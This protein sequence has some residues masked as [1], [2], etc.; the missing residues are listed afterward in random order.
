[1][2]RRRDAEGKIEDGQTR[3]NWRAEPAREGGGAGGRA[4]HDRRAVD[5]AGSSDLPRDPG[6]TVPRERGGGATR[7]VPGVG[8]GLKRTQIWRGPDVGEGPDAGQ[9]GR[10]AAASGGPANPLPAGWLVVVDGPGKGGV[11]T[12][13][14]GNNPIGRDRTQ[15][16]CLDYG[17][18]AISRV[19]HA[20]VVYDPR[21]RKFHVKGGDGTNLTYVDDELV[22]AP[23]ELE[24][25]ANL[26]V[27]NTVLRFVPLCGADFSWS[28]DPAGD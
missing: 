2:A 13:G 28:E 5:I 27:G 9:A 19:G 18:S 10:D 24:P 26:R 8:G 25:F 12:I 7:V 6:V 23:R 20:S 16:I 17:D 14:F 21:G 22:L 11:A 1:M 3:V 15:R 4:P